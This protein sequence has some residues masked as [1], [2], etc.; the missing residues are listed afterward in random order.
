MNDINQH[1]G[2]QPVIHHDGH[3]VVDGRDQ[4]SVRYGRIHAYLFKENRRQGSHQA[5]HHH[6]PTRDTPTQAEIIIE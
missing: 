2:H 1:H 5:G 4:W 3:Q 6:G